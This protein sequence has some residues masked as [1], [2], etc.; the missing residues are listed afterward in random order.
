MNPRDGLFRSELT[1]RM[2]R[3]G[4]DLEGRFDFVVATR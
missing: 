4:E 3:A 1:M 2:D